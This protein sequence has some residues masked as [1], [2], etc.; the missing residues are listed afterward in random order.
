MVHTKQTNVVSLAGMTAWLAEYG[1]DIHNVRDLSIRAEPSGQDG[2]PLYLWIDVVWY[3]TNHLGH[4]Y[5]EPG[6]G[7][8]ATEQSSIPLRSFPPLL[9]T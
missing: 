5:V 2:H 7:D 8:A 1:L 4:R 6:T 3:K 9:P